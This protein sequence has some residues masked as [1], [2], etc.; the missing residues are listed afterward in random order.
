MNLLVTSHI[1]IILDQMILFVNDITDNL[2]VYKAKV[3]VLERDQGLSDVLKWIQN[4]TVVVEGF[5]MVILMLRRADLQ[6]SDAWYGQNI[7]LLIHTVREINLSCFILLGD[8]IPSTVDSKV[9][10]SSGGSRISR[11]GGGGRQPPTWVLFSKNVC[12]NERIG[13]H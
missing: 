5:K 8:L 7:D 1:F 2:A 6:R 4:G 12:E 13:S 9:M 3:V 11:W 10:V